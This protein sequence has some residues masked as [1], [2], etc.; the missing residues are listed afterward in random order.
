MRF[1]SSEGFFFARACGKKICLWD[2]PVRKT[3]FFNIREKKIPKSQNLSL[4]LTEYSNIDTP[5]FGI[6]RISKGKSRNGDVK[7]P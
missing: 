2:C 5:K 7:K 4:F 6:K 3:T 1:L